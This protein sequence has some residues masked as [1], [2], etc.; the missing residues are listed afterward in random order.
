[1]IK[2]G[3]EDALAYAQGRADKSK[4]KIHEPVRIG[5]KAIRKRKAVEQAKVE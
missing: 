2:A 5:V 3:L 4:Y 1:M